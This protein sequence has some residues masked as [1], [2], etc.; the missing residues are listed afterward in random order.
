MS[1]KEELMRLFN[2]IRAELCEIEREENEAENSALLGR[3]F[4]YRNSY[5]LPQSDDDRWWIYRK[6]TALD[7]G[8]PVFFSFQTDI[9]GKSEV[10]KKESFGSV[11]DWQEIPESELQDAWGDLLQRLSSISL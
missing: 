9:Y 7:D 6:V 10:E 11:K 4:K 8:M 5:S 3:C 2:D 1:R